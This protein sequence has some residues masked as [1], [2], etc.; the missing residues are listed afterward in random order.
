MSYLGQRRR[1]MRRG[2]S[3]LG[4]AGPI[5]LPANPPL[6]PATPMVGAHVHLGQPWRGVSR[7]GM[8]GVSS[9]PSGARVARGAIGDGPP[10]WYQAMY[11]ASLG[12]DTQSST[13]SLTDG[14]TQWQSA[15]LDN[16]NQLLA[17]W[18]EYIKRDQI[19]RY[20]QVAATLAI[21][22]SAA[23]WRMIFR[24]GGRGDGG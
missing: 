4:G 18:Q 15:M 3:G 11:G 9:R 12:D 19:A 23:I 14:P 7:I 17:A 10:G 24:S 6:P 20:V 16:S 2:M 22:L 21:P 5:V 13:P 8:S 1:R